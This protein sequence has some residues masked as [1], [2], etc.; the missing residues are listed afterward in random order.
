MS[1]FSKWERQYRLLEQALCE[2]NVN[3]KKVRT[4]LKALRVETPSWGFADSG[5]R[6]QVFKQ[7]G[8]ARN[9]CEK[10]QD[11]AQVHRFTGVAPSVALHIPWDEV[12]NY[13][14]LKAFAAE[15]GL[16]LGAI[17]P[18][19][20]QDG[21]YRFGSIC[22][23][24]AAVRR[25]AVR[26]MLECVDIMKTTGSTILSLWFADGTNYPGQDNIRERKHRAQECL[27]A[28]YGK[29]TG[30]MRLLLEYKMFEPAFYHTDICDWGMSLALCQKLGPRAEVLVDTGHH[31]LG[32]N[33][34]HIVAFLIDEGR[35]GGFHF[36][37]KKYAD[38]DLM[39]SS[40]D[41]YQLF[42]IF[43]EIVDGEL[44]SKVKMNVAY[45]IDQN[46]NLEHKIEGMIHSVVNVQ[47]AYARALIVN[48]QA[49]ARARRR[50]DVVETQR[51]F[52]E[53]F[54]ADV[55]PLLASVRAESG[56]EPDPVAAFR[57]SGYAAK[58]VKERS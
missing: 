22:H 6:F 18:N 21:D 10:L 44:D 56:L 53:A 27:A 17:N 31:A 1:I 38:D 8:A 23:P 16:K 41:P 50:C 52:R 54:E 4:R 45:M 57:A 51:V 37:D 47:K 48:R 7:A 36:N 32:T 20:F 29:L 14:K 42:R 55:D 43:C 46:L 33:I 5:T 24:S 19:L 28:V 26:H 34:E 11:A 3:V 15:L 39:T 13:R 49:L 25:K 30:R 40:I 9:V 58:I 12:S 35:L 2:R